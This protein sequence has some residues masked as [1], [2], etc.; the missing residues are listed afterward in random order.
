MSNTSQWIGLS[1][2]GC[3]QGKEG[4][5]DPLYWHAANVLVVAPIL[6]AYSFVDQA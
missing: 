1:R 4:H 3:Q 2:L 5:A 6:D